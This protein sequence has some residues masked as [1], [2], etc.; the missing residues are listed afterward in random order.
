VNYTT[1]NGTGTGES[2]VLI[3]T[4][5]GL[6]LFGESLTEPQPPDTYV[7]KW[8]TEARPDPNCDPTEGFCEMWL[9]GNYTV[10]IG[11]HC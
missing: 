4:V 6:P 3:R 11:I 10:N 5:D 8:D 1:V 2:S 7:L 9:P